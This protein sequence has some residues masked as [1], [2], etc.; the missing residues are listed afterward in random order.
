MLFGL[1]KSKK[2]KHIKHK[3]YQEEYIEESHE[4]SHDIMQYD[5]VIA[6]NFDDNDRKEMKP[7]YTIKYYSKFKT[8]ITEAIFCRNTMCESI[9][10]NQAFLALEDILKQS[11]EDKMLISADINNNCILNYEEEIIIN[12]LEDIV[13]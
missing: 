5:V 1:F 13:R 12:K 2:E 11:I 9:T 4:E 6:T 10:L 7:I 3:E 8:S